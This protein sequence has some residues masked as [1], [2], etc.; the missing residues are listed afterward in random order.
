LFFSS[1]FVFDSPE[2]EQGVCW[3][4][5]CYDNFNEAD[6]LKH[7]GTLSCIWSEDSFCEENQEDLDLSKREGIFRECEGY[8]D[9]A[10]CSAVSYCSWH[11]DEFGSGFF[12]TG[13]MNTQNWV[14]W[15][16]SNIIFLILILVIIGFGTL[17]KLP[18]VINLGIAFFTLD[19]ISRYIG[20]IADFGG[21]TSLSVIFITGGILLIFGGWGIE[22]WRRSLLAK[23]KK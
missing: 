11:R 8:K 2:V 18:K 7:A 14:V 12:G 15:I 3:T 10:S 23:V 13:E 1:V 6:C 22:K 4:V 21:Y 17:H 16:F 9:S 19:V 5:S 20:F